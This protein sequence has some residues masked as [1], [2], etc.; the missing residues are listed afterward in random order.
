M[1]WEFNRRAFENEDG[2][3]MSE[4]RA[5]FEKEMDKNGRELWKIATKHKLTDL[6]EEKFVINMR[7]NFEITI[8]AI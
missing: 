3:S 1:R 4:M 8:G 2:F 7:N 5:I 6:T